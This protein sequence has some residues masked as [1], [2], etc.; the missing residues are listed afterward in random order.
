MEPMRNCHMSTAAVGGVEGRRAVTLPDLL[1]IGRRDGQL[2]PIARPEFNEQEKEESGS[3]SDKL[4]EHE[5]AGELN[6]LDLHPMHIGHR[7]SPQ[8]A[9]SFKRFSYRKP[10]SLPGCKTL[11][12]LAREAVADGRL[13]LS[14]EQQT[15]CAFL[16]GKLLVAGDDFSLFVPL[17]HS[18][19][20]SVSAE[21]AE[22]ISVIAVAPRQQAHDVG[23]PSMAQEVP[24]VLAWVFHCP[25]QHVRRLMSV[26]SEKGCYL[27]EL[28]GHYRV[29]FSKVKGAG[30]F[31]AVVLG[32]PAGSEDAV[33]VKL[34][35]SKVTAA[36]V[37]SEV[38]MLVHAQGHPN[39]I[40]FRG[41][42]R[43]NSQESRSDDPR[44]AILFDYYPGGDLHRRVFSE[45]DMIKEEPAM[46]WTDDLCSAL[47]HLGDK[48]IFHRDVKPENLLLAS[49]GML[50]LTDFGIA[51][52]ISNTDEMSKSKGSLGY[53]SPEVL[54][55]EATG[56][57]GDAF[58]AGLV[59]YF[60]ISKSL[61]FTGPNNAATWHNTM[62]CSI[63]FNYTCFQQKSRE[64]RRLIRS[65]VSKDPDARMTP[66]QALSVT[67]VC[68]KFVI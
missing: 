28:A 1:S 29:D 10:M 36:A 45:K 53:A 18:Q 30:G 50:V 56:C 7:F 9:L 4:H 55:G 33:A 6:S 3:T 24:D 54:M 66:R 25:R 17:L 38:E 46:R 31:G 2:A 48:G 61:P 11:H 32:F 64:C 39:I 41:C 12:D 22:D 57:Q 19:L 15:R 59:L 47:V 62:A 43:E 23:Q 52:H 49:D 16:N 40:A 27:S 37:A 14:L 21:A 63:D 67:A 13:H 65:L 51:C 58:A 35:K 8:P 68:M 5:V 42:F 34:L 20:V 44:W 60:I 26:L